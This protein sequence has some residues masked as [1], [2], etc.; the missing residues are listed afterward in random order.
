V[1]QAND[2]QQRGAVSVHAAL[3]NKKIEMCA[4]K[5]RKF[6]LFGSDKHIFL[7]YEQKQNIFTVH[8]KKPRN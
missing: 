8:D 4:P 1:P 2:H 5:N 3:S 6:A 7:W